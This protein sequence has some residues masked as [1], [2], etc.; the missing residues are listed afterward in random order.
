MANRRCFVIC[1]DSNDTHDKSLR[2]NRQYFLLSYLRNRSA[3]PNSLL[4]EDLVSS[5]KT[6]CFW[7]SY[8]FFKKKIVS[9]Y[10][11]PPIVLR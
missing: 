10:F 8:K 3:P 2:A 7:R 4:L 6:W 5:I 1:L 11:D 9:S